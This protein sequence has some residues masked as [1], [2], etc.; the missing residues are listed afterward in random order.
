MSVL[1][2]VNGK[3]TTTPTTYNPTF[4][5]YQASRGK[6]FVKTFVAKTDP[7]INDSDSPISFMMNRA[8][9]DGNLKA[10][11]DYR[12]HEQHGLLR[13]RVLTLHLEDGQPEKTNV[14]YNY[15]RVELRPV[16]YH[17]RLHD[18]FR[19]RRRNHGEHDDLRSGE[20]RNRFSTVRAIA[21]RR[22]L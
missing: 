6:G 19:S 11:Q 15:S 7:T 10:G 20:E 18:H 3:V 4:N 21:T 14:V 5:G 13:R 2:S 12:R 9:F 22:M 8:V 17:H 1:P 16:Q